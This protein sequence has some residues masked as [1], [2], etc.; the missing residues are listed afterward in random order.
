MH[1]SNHNNRQVYQVHLKMIVAWS[2]FGFIF[3]LKAFVFGWSCFC[4]H[5]LLRQC[6]NESS[7]A[8]IYQPHQQQNIRLKMWNQYSL[9]SV[10]SIVAWNF[11]F[12]IAHLTIFGQYNIKRKNTFSIKKLR[13]MLILIISVYIKKTLNKTICKRNRQIHSDAL[14]CNHCIASL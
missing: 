2:I 8:T 1:F 4:A 6:G 14:I 3:L 9:R 11:F 12:L 10:R 5:W 7:T 13:I